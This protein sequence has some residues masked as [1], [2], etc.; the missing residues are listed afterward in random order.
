MSKKFP[1]FIYKSKFFEFFLWEKVGNDISN[2]EGNNSFDIIFKSSYF[3]IKYFKL[4]KKVDNKNKDCLL[5]FKTSDL[6][7]LYKF[8]FLNYF[9]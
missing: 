9:L 5:S 3:S 6:V 7:K 1:K 8:K 2:K 4:L